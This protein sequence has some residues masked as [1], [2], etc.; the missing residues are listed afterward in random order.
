[1]RRGAR[2]VLKWFSL[3]YVIAIIVQ[4][5]LAG[6]GVFRMYNIKNSDDCD[7]AAAHCIANSKTLDAHRGMGFILTEPVALLFLIVALI[8]WF[9]DVRIRVV[10]IVAPILTF[11]QAVLAVVGGWVGGLHPVNGFLILFLYGWLFYK[12]RKGTPETAT[13]AEPAAVP[14]G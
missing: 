12:L 13:T 11:V 5:F 6:E 9:P 8:A 7:K 3:L 1:M 10:S 2:A 14:T 4:V